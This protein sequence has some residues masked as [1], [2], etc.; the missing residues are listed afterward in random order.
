MASRC[1]RLPSSGSGSSE[2]PKQTSFPPWN[3]LPM[4]DSSL[5]E[6]RTRLRMGTRPVKALVLSIIGWFV[7]M[8]RVITNGIDASAE[9][10]S[11]TL[12]P[13]SKPQ[14]GV[15]SSEEAP[16]P[17]TV[18]TKRRFIMEPAQLMIFGCSGL[19]HREIKSGSRTS[20]GQA[21]T[22]RDWSNK[23]RTV[24][25]F[26]AVG[27]PRLSLETRPRRVLAITIIGS[28]A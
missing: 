16:G 27:R 23:H 5:A 11:I 6:H 10:A 26:S 3:K 22:P 12:R 28:S 19:T 1:L 25:S 14:T 4:E 8:P 13:L 7:W 17:P 2:T 20:E 24:D 15:S 21:M 18:A 9:Q